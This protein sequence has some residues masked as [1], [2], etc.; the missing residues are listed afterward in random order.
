VKGA[1]LLMTTTKTSVLMTCALAVLVIGLSGGAVFLAA[2]RSS[3]GRP[4]PALV[5]AAATQPAPD[6]RGQFNLAYALQG[7]AVVRHIAAPFPQLR[8]EYCRAEM[9]SNENQPPDMMVFE[10]DGPSLRRLG[11]L[12]GSQ[13]VASVLATVAEIRPAETDLPRQLLDKPVSGDWVVRRGATRVQRIEAVC[14]ELAPVLGSGMTLRTSQ[15]QRETIVVS[16]TFTPP[17][18][19]DSVHLQTSP[20]IRITQDLARPPDGGKQLRGKATEILHSIGDY[21]NM[22]VELIITNAEQV[23]DWSIE[24]SAD[25][26]R[27]KGPP[28]PAAVDEILANIAAQTSLE[29]HRELKPVPVWR[30]ERK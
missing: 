29:I 13:T 26:R 20:P 17:P 25:L 12:Y 14:D 6:W 23:A 28:D 19:A 30:L 1:I 27:W 11:I 8:G 2:R 21:V 4:D 7:D 24:P 10:A 9:L 22:P 16:G 5:A 15:V 3:V 18:A